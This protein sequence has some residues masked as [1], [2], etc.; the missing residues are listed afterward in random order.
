MSRY[1]GYS[2]YCHNIL[3]KTRGTNPK[4]LLFHI[5]RFQYEIFDSKVQLYYL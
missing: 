4:F 2:D 5:E 1:V 3:S